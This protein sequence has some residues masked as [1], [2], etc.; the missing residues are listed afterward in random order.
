MY[1][2]WQLWTLIHK[3]LHGLEY[4]RAKLINYV[5]LSICFRNKYLTLNR[6]RLRMAIIPMLEKKVSN[7]Y[8]M[9]KIIQA[10]TD[11]NH[12][13]LSQYFA[14]HPMQVYKEKLWLKF[15]SKNF[16][17]TYV[18][19]LNFEIFMTRKVSYSCNTKDKVSE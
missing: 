17:D 1:K 2:L 10:T 7:V 5:V 18:N 6:Y 16:L 11:L 8:K 15:W 9:R 14:E 19:L 4:F 3:K 13:V 12:K